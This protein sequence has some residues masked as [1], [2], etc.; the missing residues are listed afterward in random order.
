MKLMLFGISIMLFG[1]IIILSGS[2]M[3]SLEWIFVFIGFIVCS[4]AY[5]KPE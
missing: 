2:S 1:G 4:L 3:Y 5:F